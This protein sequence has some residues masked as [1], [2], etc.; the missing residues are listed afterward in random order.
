M[1]HWFEQGA[2]AQDFTERYEHYTRVQEEFYQDV[3]T[4]KVGDFFELEAT[5]SDIS[6]FRPWLTPRFWDVQR[7][8]NN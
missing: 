7:A 6:G 1:D 5:R 4:I 8:G 2:A 3:T